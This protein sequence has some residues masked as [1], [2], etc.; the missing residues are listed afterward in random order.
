[1]TSVR[2]GE[3][4][5][6]PRALATLSGAFA[7]DPLLR[8]VFPDD[9]AWPER[10]AGFF[11]FLFD[12]R[13]SGGGEVR[14]TDDVTA[15]SLW[16][17]PGGNRLAPAER[18]SLWEAAAAEFSVGERER[19]DRFAHAVRRLEP[20]EP[21]WYLGV[22]GTHPAWQGQGL[23]ALV[24]RPV[25]DEADAHGFPTCLETAAERNLGFYRRLG[26]TVHA[27]LVVPGGGPRLWVLVREPAGRS[28]GSGP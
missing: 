12:S 21:H 23:G 15:V 6:R 3:P 18:A 19:F 1:M 28:A 27:E 13:V 9:A 24:V 16:S 22:L 26:F 5:D 2:R 7:E 4:R 20:E 14:V 17:P 10:A 11:G 25:L 8:W